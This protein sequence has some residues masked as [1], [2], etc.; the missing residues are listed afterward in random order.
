MNEIQVEIIRA[1]EGNRSILT[2]N[3]REKI[4]FLEECDK[5]DMKWISGVNVCKCT[6][7]FNPVYFSCRNC[8]GLRSSY[9]TPDLSVIDW[10]DMVG[11]FQKS[12]AIF[13]Y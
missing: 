3:E 10:S 4:A 5:M 11:M 9:A 6:P 1:F 7:L 12:E 8:E 13:T 2:T